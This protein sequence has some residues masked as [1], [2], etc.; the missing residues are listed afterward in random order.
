MGFVIALV[1]PSPNVIRLIYLGIRSWWLGIN[2]TA[3]LTNTISPLCIHFTHFVQMAHGNEVLIVF[4]W[5]YR[6]QVDT[7]WWK[8]ISSYVH[9]PSRSLNQIIHWRRISIYADRQ[10]HK[11]PEL[12]QREQTKFCCSYWDIT[13]IFCFDFY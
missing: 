13:L 10:R 8:L 5:C 11:S 1:T 4:R 9:S 7:H 6:K 2:E 3:G 12:T